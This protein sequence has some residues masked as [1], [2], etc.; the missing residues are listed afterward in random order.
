MSQHLASFLT[1]IFSGRYLERDIMV[2]R[3]EEKVG[4]FRLQLFPSSGSSAE[5]SFALTRYEKLISFYS[6]VLSKIPE[7]KEYNRLIIR[8]V[9]L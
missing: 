6:P 1:G 2:K 3:R 8:E 9:G 4:F 5:Y 7:A